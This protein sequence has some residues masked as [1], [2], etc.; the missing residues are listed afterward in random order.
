[1]H[2]KNSCIVTLLPEG[3]YRIATDAE[4]AA[5]SARVRHQ[6]LTDLYY[7][8]EEIKAVKAEAEAGQSAQDD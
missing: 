3:G 5:H 4:L 6:V 8:V 2:G 1:M 7:Q